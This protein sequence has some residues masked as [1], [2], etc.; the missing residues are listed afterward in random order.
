MPCLLLQRQRCEAEPTNRQAARAACSEQLNKP[1]A[2]V[3]AGFFSPF[4][5]VHRQA[6]HVSSS[7]SLQLSFRFS[8]E[9]FRGQPTA[10]PI[11]RVVAV[12][13]RA[14]R[15]GFLGTRPDDEGRRS[16]REGRASIGTWADKAMNMRTSYLH[17]HHVMH[18]E[19]KAK[20]EDNDH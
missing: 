3:R 9:R 19:R 14:R 6:A 11:V 20:I 16:L 7:T 12:K 17:H 1:A 4:L 8:A 10:S 15:H 13:S 2:S 5:S 18:G